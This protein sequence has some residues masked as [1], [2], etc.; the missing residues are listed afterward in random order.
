MENCL[1]TIRGEQQRR[2]AEGDNDNDDN[3]RRPGMRQVRARCK[4][5]RV[6]SLDYRVYEYCRRKELRGDCGVQKVCFFD[7][8]QFDLT[9]KI[10]KCF[11]FT[12][13]IF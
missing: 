3:A 13:L 12:F 4:M 2:I 9:L 7:I 6:F 5:R 1:L 11:N 8:F 10:E